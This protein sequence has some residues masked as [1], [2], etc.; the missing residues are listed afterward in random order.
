MVSERHLCSSGG[1]LVVRATGGG[2]PWVHARV[3]ADPVVVSDPFDGTSQE[4]FA[5]IEAGRLARR[6]SGAKRN[7]VMF[8]SKTGK[9][10]E[11]HH[12]VLVSTGSF[13]PPTY[14][15]LRCF[16]DLIRA[17]HRVAMCKLAKLR[18]CYG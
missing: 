7:F 15:H 11:K 17:E 8:F 16:D 5:L 1:V 12:V 13:N 9:E 6:L 2:S 10:W 18:F 4:D 3:H 14:M